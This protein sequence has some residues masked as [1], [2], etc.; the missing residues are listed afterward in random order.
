MTGP[1]SPGLGSRCTQPAFIG[2]VALC[3]PPGSHLG[4]SGGEVAGL[5]VQ[6]N[7]SDCPRMSQHALVLGSH[8]HFE[9]NL[10]VPAQPA[11]STIQSDPSHESVKPG[12]PCLAPRVSVIKEHPHPALFPRICRPRR[13]QTVWPLW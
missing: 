9:P 6:E 4:Q 12:S 13:V 11:D 7:H 2:S 10:F 3:L 8:G 5:L 1:R